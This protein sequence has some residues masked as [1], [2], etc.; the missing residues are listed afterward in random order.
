MIMSAILLGYGAGWCYYHRAFVGR[1]IEK[2]R[3][4]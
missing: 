1:V 4:L 2:I 3:D